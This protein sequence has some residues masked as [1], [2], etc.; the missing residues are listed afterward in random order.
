[1]SWGSHFTH[2]GRWITK[3]K[4]EPVLGFRARDVPISLE[5]VEM[6]LY[7]SLILL[8][9][10]ILLKSSVHQCFHQTSLPASSLVLASQVFLSR[11]GQFLHCGLQQWDSKHLDSE[12]VICWQIPNPGELSRCAAAGLSW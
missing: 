6:I 11:K 7:L 8:F 4:K 1:M 2:G 5:A 9:Q 10:M 3:L 12:E